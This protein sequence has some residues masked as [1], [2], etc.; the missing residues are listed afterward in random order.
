MQKRPPR[1]DNIKWL[2]Q[3]IASTKRIVEGMESMLSPVPWAPEQDG[4]IRERSQL[5]QIADR[6]DRIAKRG[7]VVRLK[8]ETALT[9]AA[10]LSIAAASPITEHDA[11][12]QFGHTVEHWTGAVPTVLAYCM[13]GHLAGGAWHAYAVTVPHREIVVRWGPF[14]PKRSSRDLKQG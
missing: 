6:I 14:T 9:V 4:L 13:T 3:D 8:P 1:A 12:K 2:D 5:E 7:E 11:R 10:A